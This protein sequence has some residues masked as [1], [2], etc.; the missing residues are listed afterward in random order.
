MTRK[1]GTAKGLVGEH[2][3]ISLEMEIANDDELPVLLEERNKVEKQ[4]KLKADNIDRFVV[5]LSRRDSLIDAEI[6]HLKDEIQRLRNRKSALHQ[7]KHYMN[8]FL[9]PF[10][11]QELGDEN[12]V[13][14]TDIARYKMYETFGELVVLDPEKV[15]DDFIKT[16]IIQKVDKAK[17]RKA[18]MSLYKDNKDMPDGLEIRRVKRVRRS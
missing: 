2:I 16:E 6:E 4:I 7:T 12:G 15:P 18:C 13:Y 3:E 17:A 5:E 9:I 1:K 10:I 8:G 14:E 11:V